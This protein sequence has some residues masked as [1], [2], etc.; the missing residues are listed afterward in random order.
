[1]IDDLPE[2]LSDKILFSTGRPGCQRVCNNAFSPFH[3]IKLTK[4]F[5]RGMEK[6]MTTM[7]YLHF[8]RARKTMNKRCDNL[9]YL[10][11]L[12]AQGQLML[13]RDAG[14]PWG[15]EQAA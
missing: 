6:L 1:M 4:C 15:I 2:T 8:F 10:L 11:V 13:E 14:K 3:L 7:K 5:K 12:K 9:N